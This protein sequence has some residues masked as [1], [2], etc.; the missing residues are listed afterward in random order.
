[1]F[2]LESPHRG[3]SNE[4][5]QYTIFHIKKK[6]T[7]N[8]PKSAGLGF[9]QYIE[10]HIIA[11]FWRHPVRGRIAIVDLRLYGNCHL[12]LPSRWTVGSCR[13]EF[14]SHSKRVV[15]S[16]RWQKKQGNVLSK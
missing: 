15:P 7:L 14:A 5:T 9:R 13:K 11:K 16:G 10:E 2:S 6:F 4:Y 1:M 12:F 3:D 8:Y